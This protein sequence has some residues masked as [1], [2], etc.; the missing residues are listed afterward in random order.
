[1][2]IYSKVKTTKIEVKKKKKKEKENLFMYKT[3]ICGDILIEE[4][5]DFVQCVISIM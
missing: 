1:M 3:C 4:I 2:I 5:L